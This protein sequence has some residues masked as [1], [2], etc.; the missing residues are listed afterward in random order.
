LEPEHDDIPPHAE[1]SGARKLAFAAIGAAVALLVVYGVLQRDRHPATTKDAGPAP[2][3]TPVDISSSVP[4]VVDAGPIDAGPPEPTEVIDAGANACRIVFGPVQQ[5]FTGPGALSISGSNV[6]VAT[7]SNG[8]LHVT[9]FPVDSTGAKRKPLGATPLKASRPPC[10][11]A[12]N[13]AFCSDGNG[14]VHRALR[15]Q[16]SDQTYVH[17][18]PG[19]RIAA[20]QLPGGHVALAYMAVYNTTEGHVSQAFVRIDDEEPFRISD[21][22]AGATDVTLAER[23]SELLVLYVDARLAMS[24]L[25]ARTISYE[26]GKAHVGPDEVI[27]VGGG[28]DHQVLVAL[29]SDSSGAMLGLMPTTADDVFGMAA[30]KIEAPPKIDEP[31]EIS[32][33]LNG[34][35]TAPIT[36]TLG[37]KKMYIA[38]VRPLTAA[39]T[40]VRGLELGVAAGGGKFSYTTLGYVAS[41]G[42]VKDVALMLDT[43]TG[44]LWVHY[45]DQDGSWLERRTCP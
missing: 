8:I 40:S 30:V 20:A 34:I 14:A 1:P 24:P 11:V 41:A 33:Y 21:E 38:S 26:A 9:P 13:Y 12:G 37:G 7:H 2:S 19:A 35:N 10:A 32:P 44:S 4:I 6:E 36:G 28:S 22:G 17:A 45:T 43:K 31:S 27:Y 5:P 18:D 29:A 25:H 23:G 39:A 15:A 3:E 16:A 42:S